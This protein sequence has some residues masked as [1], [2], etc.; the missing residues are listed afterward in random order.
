[1]E[2]NTALLTTNYQVEECLALARNGVPLL[3]AAKQMRVP[4]A[5]TNLGDG[6]ADYIKEGASSSQL[7]QSK[8]ES[9]A[10]NQ[11]KN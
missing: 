2:K 1:L 3:E 8:K 11:S 6:I 5:I 9:Q 4:V 7:Q 10:I